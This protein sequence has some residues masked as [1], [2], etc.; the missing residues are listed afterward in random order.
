MQDAQNNRGFRRSMFLV[1]L[2]VGFV[3]LGI[4]KLRWLVSVL[5]PIGLD[6]E[7]PDVLMGTT[8]QCLIGGGLVAFIAG[9]ILAL[10]RD[11]ASRAGWLLGSGVVLLCLGWGP[12]IVSIVAA[13]LGLTADPNPNPI[14]LGTLAMLT[15]IPALALIILGLVYRSEAKAIRSS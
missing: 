4:V 8:A 14:L 10:A 2:G 3:A 6:S 1:P 11:P 15:F 7:T 13:N 5:V 9:I 12:L